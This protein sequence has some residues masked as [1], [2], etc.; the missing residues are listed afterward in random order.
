MKLFKV[1]LVLVAL[2]SAALACNEKQKSSEWME[3]DRRSCYR[4]DFNMAFVL[5]GFR[6]LV[7]HIKNGRWQKST[8]EMPSIFDSWVRRNLSFLQV[9][10]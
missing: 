9:L 3:L 1:T 5:V 7:L 2:L 10:A 8:S 6:L 4:T